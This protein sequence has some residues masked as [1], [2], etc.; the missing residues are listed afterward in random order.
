MYIICDGEA[1]F[2]SVAVFDNFAVLYFNMW[3]F[4]LFLV[5]GH[6]YTQMYTKP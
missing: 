4:I 2:Q 5:Y 1:G 6:L 3:Q